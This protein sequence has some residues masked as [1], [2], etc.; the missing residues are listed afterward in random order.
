M[1]ITNELNYFFPNFMLHVPCPIPYDCWQVL[2]WVSSVCWETQIR[3]HLYG[4]NFGHGGGRLFKSIKEKLGKPNL[5]DIN[6]TKVRAHPPPNNRKLSRGREGRKIT[7][8]LLGTASEKDSCLSFTTLNNLGNEI[9]RMT[10][11]P[12]NRTLGEY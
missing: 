4:I 6:S 5:L 9:S 10:G 11:R 1:V 12:P 8:D 3:K 7:L 2:L